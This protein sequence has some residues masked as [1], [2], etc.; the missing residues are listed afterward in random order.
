MGQMRQ[1]YVWDKEKEKLVTEEEYYNT[2]PTSSH[3]VI[4]DTMPPTWHPADG[5]VYESKSA[6]RQVTK[7]HGLV[8]FGNDIKTSDAPQRREINSK[9]DKARRIEAIQ[10]AMAETNFKIRG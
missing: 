4:Q 2:R 9:Q 1:R 10:R 6:F 7:A 3:Y 8:E 5:K